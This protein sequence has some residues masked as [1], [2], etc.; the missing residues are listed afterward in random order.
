MKKSSKDDMGC[1]SVGLIKAGKYA[2]ASAPCRSGFSRDFFQK[3]GEIGFLSRLK[4]LL[5][6][7][8]R[9]GRIK[10]C[11]E[12]LEATGLDRGPDVPHQLQVVVKVV[13]RRQHRG[14]DLVAAVQM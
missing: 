14:Q 2:T 3:T 5:H 9:P 7:F 10:R 13:D 8:A 4:P 12:L 6:G 1:E 11:A